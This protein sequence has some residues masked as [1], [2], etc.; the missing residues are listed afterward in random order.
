MFLKLKSLVSNVFI[1]FVVFAVVLAGVF[2]VLWSQGVL[3][4]INILYIAAVVFGVVVLF[5]LLV[6]FVFVAKPLRT[7]LTQV[8]LVL[9]G[10]PFKKIFTTRVDEVGLLAHFFN[11]VT[12]GFVRVASDIKDRKRILDE[13]AVA[14]ELQSSIFPNGELKAK[15]IEVVVKNRPAT[16]LGGDIFDLINSNGKAYMYVGDVTGHGVTA[17]LIMA[18]VNAMIRAFSDVYSSAKDI[19]VQTNKNIKRYVKPS[20]FMTLVMLCWDENTEKMTYVGAGHER[21]IIFRKSKGLIEEIV[22]GG[23]ALG[24]VPD[25]SKLAQEKEIPLEKGDM[26]VLY[27]DGITE[28]KNQ[29][30]SLYGVEGLKA[31]VVEYGQRY[32]ASGLNFHIAED[33]S[34][35]VGD[36]SQ[37]D[38]MTL[39]V[40]EKT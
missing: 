38:D 19:V 8:Q 29:E 36:E 28:A 12:E 17:G 11:Q 3:D 18:M 33:V 23:T 13:L 40:I 25:V 31:S 2:Y 27:S 10:K 35:F 20:M 4:G 15:G 30:G 24:F 22:S 14:T 1:G 5:V 32:G 9:N 39:I 37:L 7:V 6:L 26:I 16:E 34:A 21:I